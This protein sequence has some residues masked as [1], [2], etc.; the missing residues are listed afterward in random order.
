V[1]KKINPA[2]NAIKKINRLTA[3][4]FLEAMTD[5]LGDTVYI[6]HILAMMGQ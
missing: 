5:V 4:T 6:I 3:L 1:F 2:I